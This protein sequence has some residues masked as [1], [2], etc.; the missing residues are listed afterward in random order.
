M[1]VGRLGI[2]DITMPESVDVVVV[3]V[4]ISP[5]ILDGAVVTASEDVVHFDSSDDDS[6]DGG[7]SEGGWVDFISSV[8]LWTASK[9]E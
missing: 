9:R 1:Y 6:I 8:I 3:V 2:M 5:L 4:A 7:R